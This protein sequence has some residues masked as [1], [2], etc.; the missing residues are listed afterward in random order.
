MDSPPTYRLQGDVLGGCGC[1]LSLDCLCWDDSKR[2]G[3]DSFV[4]YHIREGTIQSE[5]VALLCVVRIMRESDQTSFL[6]I[7]ANASDQQRQLLVQAFNGEFGGVL[8]AVSQVFPQIGVPRIAP[9]RIVEDAGSL[10]LW[11]GNILIRDSLKRASFL[12]VKPL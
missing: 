10:A 7:D 5:E 4:A 1:S 9:I 2:K 6:Y 3:C 12:F 11:I 8:G